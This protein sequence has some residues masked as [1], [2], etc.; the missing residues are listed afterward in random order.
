MSNTPQNS[1]IKPIRTLKTRKSTLKNKDDEKDEEEIYEQIKKSDFKQQR[2]PAWRPVPTIASIISVYTIFGLIFLA[3]GIVLY[4][5]SKKIKTISKRYDDQC[6][7]N[8]EKNCT[9]E[10][11]INNEMKSPVMIYYKLDGFFQNSR[12]YVQSKNIDQLRGKK[13]SLDDLK[14]DC[15]PI[16]YNKDLDFENL[17][18]L[19]G[20]SLNLDDVAVPCGLVAKTFFNDTFTNWTI[21]DN[22]YTVDETNI[23]FARD[24]ELFNDEYNKTQQWI[25]L[26][27]EHFIV[28]MRPSGLMNPKKL[29]GRI[30]QDLKKGDVVKVDV[31]NFYDVSMYNGKKFLV[32]ST[33]TAFG[34]NMTFLGI[35]FI[36]V[37]CISLILAVVFPIGYSLTQKRGKTR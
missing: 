26:I 21:N 16:V 10:I 29:W 37:G 17:T 14:D 15:K 6:L 4:L 7:L 30:K 34:G 33:T 5:F 24:I 31:G 35:S 2:L 11:T 8:S 9:I 1:N 36:V 22:Y 18:N 12:R 25:S 28:W 19:E 23:A 3:F 20:E 13:T 32:L 27:D